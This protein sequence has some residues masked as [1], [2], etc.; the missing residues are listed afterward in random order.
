MKKMTLVGAVAVAALM[1]LPVTASRAAAATAVYVAPTNGSLS[2]ESSMAF[3]PTADPTLLTQLDNQQGS[4]ADSTMFSQAFQVQADSPVGNVT[5]WGTGAGQTGFMVSI[6]DGV[7]PAPGSTAILPNGPA[8]D[9]TLAS[10]SVVPLASVTQTPAA[11][12]LTQY[13][14]DIPT[15]Q[16]LATHAYRVTVTAVG[17]SFEWAQSSSPGCCTGT[18]AV[19]WVRGRLQSYLGAYNVAFQLNNTTTVPA[20]TTDPGATATT[21][22]SRYSF[23]A[24][25]SGSAAPTVRWQRS[26]DAGA[27]WADVTGAT[28]TTLSGTAAAGDTGALFRAVFTNVAGS[29]TSN[30]A[31]LTV[32]PAPVGIT[33]AKLTGSV[34]GTLKLK[35]CTPS[36]KTDKSATAPGGLLSSGGTLTWASSGHT[37]VVT[38]AATSPGQGACKKGAV[39]HDVT[40]TVTGGTSTVT[41]PGDGMAVRYCQSAKNGA[42]SLVTGTIAHF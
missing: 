36:S 16:V 29:A 22:G 6:M 3:T 26:N 31:A 9:G 35:A 42:L 32:G 28:G 5:W 7:W 18:Q 27:T 1:A 40:G 34:T 33:C 38:V 10:L 17:G 20:V 11:G 2:M 39:E 4:D 13:S 21:V 30:S 25:A 41:T 8:V 37:T 23:T 19:D 24:A 15:I 14:L 12:G